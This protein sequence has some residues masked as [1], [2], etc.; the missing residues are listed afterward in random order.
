MGPN[1]WVKHVLSQFSATV[2]EVREG[3]KKVRVVAILELLIGNIAP[4]LHLAVTDQTGKSIVMEY[5]KVER[6]KYLIIRFT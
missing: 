4:P 5:L 3:L 2:E 6:K 1:D